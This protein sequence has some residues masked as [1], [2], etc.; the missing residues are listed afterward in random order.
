MSIS[1]RLDYLKMKSRH[2]K[3]LKPWHKKWWGIII[4]ILIILIIIIT[5]ISTIIVIKKT[6]EIIKQRNEQGVEMSTSNYLKTIEGDGNNY[7]LG[8][9][10]SLYQNFINNKE[11]SI[12]DI[13]VFSNFS[14]QFSANSAKIMR[15]MAEEFPDVRF[16]FRDSPSQDS[17]I[18]AIAARCAGEQNNFWQ[19]H[20]LIFS[21]QSELSLIMDEDE[22]KQLLKLL[23]QDLDINHTQFN[24]CL[25]DRR[26][27]NLVR[28]DYI[29]GESL[30]IPGTPT[31]YINGKRITGTLS[32]N[33]FR[34]LISGL[35]S[36]IN[37]E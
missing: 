15:K 13:V 14:C 30:N 26:Y 24:T 19:M 35:K 9:K 23:A 3:Q 31:W 22:K 36:K 34:D 2:Q 32:E 37:Q 18:S 7:Y 21:I 29:D 4:V 33:D 5:I 25:D 12:I 10:Q 27:V 1:D 11:E 28:Q 17:I 16:V 20:D 6:N 8:P